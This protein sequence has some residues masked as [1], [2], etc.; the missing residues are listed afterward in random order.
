MRA[1]R[2]RRPGGGPGHRP[3][4]PHRQQVPACRPGLWRLL[5]SQGHAGAAAQRPSS[6]AA[7]CASSRA[8]SRSTSSRKRRDGPARSSTRCGG[9]VAGKTIG[10]PRR[11]L[12]A[13]HRRHAREP[14]PGHPAGA[15]CRRGHG[16]V[17]SIPRAWRRRPSCCPR[18]SWCED[19]LRSPLHGADALV[20][21]TEWNEFRGLD[22]ARC[23]RRCVR[24]PILID[25]RNIFDPEQMAPPGSPIRAS[26]APTPAALPV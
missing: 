21:L 3:R 1:G 19:R 22:L 17:P 5:L 16:C 9:S 14:E 26:A 20:V 25:L 6:T 12:Q 18:S 24:R 13:Q 8:W 7:R 23:A 11:D 15:A 4:R 10:D 2:R